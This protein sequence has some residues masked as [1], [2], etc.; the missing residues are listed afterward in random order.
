M[1]I[2]VVGCGKVGR[3][4]TTQLIQ[5]NNNVTVIDTNASLIRN[6]STNYDVMGIVGNGSSFTV[7]SQA[8]LEHADMLIAVT[9]SDEVNLLT[10]VIAK[11]N[12]TRCHTIAR[13]RSPHYSAE[14][15]FL[16][17]GLN[18]SMTINPELEAAKE[19]AR[20]LNFPQAIEIFSFAKD[21]IDML[22]FRVPRNSPLL[23]KSLKALAPLT[24]NL[25]VCIIE[26]NNKIM[27]PHGDTVIQAGDILT[28]IAMPADAQE[29]FKKIGVRTNKCKDVMIV[30]GGDITYYLSKILRD[31]RINVKIIE[32]DMDRCEE[33]V[34]GLPGVTV[35]FGDVIE[36]LQLDS[37]V[38]PKKLTAQQIVQYVRAAGNSME[39]NVETLY[40]LMNGRVEALE[41]LID[42]ESMIIGQKLVDMKIKEGVLIAGIVRNGRL[43][44]P[45]GQ[46][47]FHV[48]DT[49]IVVTVHLGFHDIYNILA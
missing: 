26:R 11:L 9:E 44:I 3:T 1:Q 34:E 24:T 20:L 16:Q 29:F 25:L 33:L 49:V 42:K 13:V 28:I 19:I 5:E 38:N 32:K 2:I 47:E 41:F 36:G 7:L 27:V 48:G 8:D 40:R 21:R 22:R 23:G 14:R 31:N 17:R 43:I 6:I 15:H 18:L 35:D 30:G 46:D 12:N 39:S 10:C 45:G 37:V 4:I